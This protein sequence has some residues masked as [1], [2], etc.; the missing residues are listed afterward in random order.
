M[1]DY[2]LKNCSNFQQLLPK[3]L[4][5]WPAVRLLF[6][7]DVPLNDVEYRSVELTG[8]SFNGQNSLVSLHRCALF[9]EFSFSFD[10]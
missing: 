2:I 1:R 3:V 6:V 5:E 4:E 10:G 7:Y 8:E 9:R